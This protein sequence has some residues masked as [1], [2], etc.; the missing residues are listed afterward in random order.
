MVI[1]ISTTKSSRFQT[2][3]VKQYISSLSEKLGVD[4]NVD[5]V[6]VSFFQDLKLRGVYIED[7]HQDTLLFAPEILVDID[8]FSISEKV[9]LV[10]EITLDKVY[11]NLKK[12]KTD[13]V[14]NLQFIVNHFAKKD[15]T[16]SSNWK[17]GLN[18]LNVSDS[19]FNYTNEHFKA[20]N[21]GVDYNHISLSRLTLKASEIDFI[22]Q[23]V[24]CEII[25]LQLID[26]S[27]FNLNNLTTS[28]NISP[29]GI[30]TQNLKLETE[31]TKLD[32]DVTFISNEY[33][34]WKQFNEKIQIKS[35]F[36]QSDISDNDLFYFVPSIECLGLKANFRGEIKGRISKL[37]GRKM[38]I[39]LNNGSKFRGDL[40]LNG[41][42]DVENTFFHLKITELVT[43]PNQLRRLKKAPFCKNQHIE[44]PENLNELGLVRFSGNLTGFYYDFFSD[45][46]WSTALGDLNTSLGLKN[47]DGKFFYSGEFST[48]EFELGK[49]LK[50]EKLVGDLAI[51]GKIDG[52]GNNLKELKADLI[53]NIKHIEFKG[54]DYNYV[55]VTGGFNE[56]KFS[57]DLLVHDEN[58]DFDFKGEIDLSKEL[59]EFH[60][61]SY[62]N[63]ANLV[64]LN[65]TDSSGL[66]P[67]LSSKLTANF[68]GDNIDNMVGAID[69]DSL[70]YFDEN[71]TIDVQS[72]KLQVEKIEEG[73]KLAVASEVFEGK[74]VGEYH[75]N[76]LFKATSNNMV[77]FI[78]S[79]QDG[80]HKQVVLANNFSF[81]FTVYNTDLLSKVALGGVELAPTTTVSG[82]F[83]S[84]HQS[85]AING[86]APWVHVPWATIHNLKLDAK[87]NEK[88]L[89][90]TVESDKIAANDSLFIQNFKSINLVQNDSIHTELSWN[91]TD[92]ILH[93][94]GT[95]NFS[96]YFH[97]LDHF[98]AKFY[99]SHANLGDTLWSVNENNH[100][101]YHHNVDSLGADSVLN[102]F[103]SI[104]SL[105]FSSKNQSI[106]IDGVLS[107]DEKDQVD[108]A[109]KDF[110]ISNLQKFIPEHIINVRGII[111]GVSSIKKEQKEYIFTADLGLKELVVN[112]T[113]L[114]NGTLKSAWKT[115]EK[116]LHVDGQLYK[117]H[118]PSIV[119]VGDYYPF[120]KEESLDFDIKLQRTNLKI[121]NSYTE[122]YV[123]D[124]KGIVSADVKL[125]GTPKTPDFNGYIQMQNT[126]FA[127]D[128]LK[129]S[130]NA[131]SCKINLYPD[132]VSFDNVKFF[133]E[134]GNKAYANGTIFHDYFKN[135][136][137]DI[138]L[139]AD[140]FM[141]LNTT[142][143]DNKL[144]YGSAAV[145]GLMNVGGYGNQ[146]DIDLDVTTN[147]GTVLNIP[148]S[149]NEDVEENNFIEFVTNDTLNQ[150]EKEDVDLSNIIMNFN[151]QATPDAEVRLV[152]DDQVGDV[153]KA[154]GEGDL[155]FVIDSYGEFNIFGEY[156]IK[157]GDYLFTLQN[158]INKRFDMEEG[159][160]IVWN[161]TPYDA[162]LD[163]TAVYRLRARLYELLAG[164]EDSLTANVYKKRVPVNLKLRMTKSM[165]KPDIAFDIDL[166]TT[167]ET[168][169]GKVR[170]ILYVSNQEENIQELNKQVFSL[171][172]LNQFIP[173]YGQAGGSYSNVG[174]TTSSELLSNQLSN[175]LSK[176]SNDFDIGI[177]YRP[178]DKLSSQ[179]LEL[180]LSTQI[181]NDRL[182]LDGNFGV[183]DNNSE[184]TGN[185][186]TNNLIGDFSME[187]K[188]TEDGKLRVK[189]FNASN[190]TYLER[191]SS[192][193]TQGVGLFY[194]KEFNSFNELFRKGLRSK[195]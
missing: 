174:A 54:Y 41:L 170:S 34:D 33:S 9:V 31:E 176:I 83:D 2:F 117:G 59:P 109:L 87:T 165:L 78:P 1:G 185:Q 146:L 3:L 63:K 18:N 16:S 181:F 82:D 112:Q 36:N 138:G 134:K 104:R 147:K 142:E 139:D 10:D 100:I 45:G 193:F 76:E 116:I 5:N 114:G 113:K 122:Q 38:F 94:N 40:D 173:P 64:Q 108:I 107:E 179:E 123:S 101:T 62:L 154:T 69:L 75:L 97:G 67:V 46:D 22:P 57:G 119:L 88:T 15:S 95:I 177:N 120:K 132:M 166:P 151:L 102:S 80:E 44:I 195:K 115:N 168:T 106:L 77:K 153:M 191:T 136:S 155:N 158:V 152:F 13:S 24:N 129:T 84:K 17:F 43:S 19:R 86:K 50:S 137:V 175:W 81:D 73:K 74:I 99:N 149:D 189:A 131:P 4:I 140:N 49:L 145:S 96:T 72:V 111:N 128:Y 79:M 61:S 183:A 180:A 171:L 68:V 91:N 135:F 20:K 156:R 98:D 28:F 161:G 126:G 159:G 141:V 110:N 190:Q 118:I 71:D 11:F 130:F 89:N 192:N 23:G 27:G 53:A 125:T 52:S 194:R 32:G 184:F 182:I 6:S 162:Q 85:L 167:D 39:S 48:S 133:D 163:L 92:S 8:E 12:Y 172:V 56:Q 47:K 21:K 90:L 150:Q 178:G 51:R 58:I 121:I 148:L 188:I 186:G 26:R 25:R 127:V 30:I 55:E 14:L 164:T 29:K 105:G 157:D 35:F 143:K 70:H 124:L 169:R 66:N 7:L 160:K 103:L 37:K 60:F 42:P 93:S 144:Y 65:L 187:Y